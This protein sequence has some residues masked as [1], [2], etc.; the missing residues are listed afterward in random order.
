[1]R[2]IP[3]IGL[4]IILLFTCHV[5]HAQV[6]GIIQDQNGEPLLGASVLIKNTSRGVTT[7]KSGYFYLVSTP[8]TF[9]LVVSYVGS[10]TKFVE[11]K[12]NARIAITLQ[13]EIIEMAEVVIKSG[14]NPAI[15][16][17]RKTIE[18][19]RELNKLKDHYKT[20]AYTKGIVLSKNG[21]DRL[22]TMGIVDS[23]EIR[24]SAGN[25]ILYLAESL[26]ELTKI[27][28]DSKENILSS[29]RS[30]DTRGIALNFL[31]FFNIEFNENYV[32]FQKKVVNPIGSLAFQYYNY[33][34]EGSYY[35]DQQK[36]YKINVI[37][38]RKEEAVFF[39]SIYIAD[40]Y[41]VLKQ[42]DLF[43]RGGN[44]GIDLM[45]SLLVKQSFIQIDKF[46]K[47]MPLAQ[48]MEFKAGFF[49][50]K[51]EGSFL[52]MYNEY[53]M[54]DENEV[55]EDKKTVIEFDKLAGKK[56]NEYWDSLRPIKL[57]EGEMFD[58]KKRDSIAIVQ[59]GRPYLDSMDRV[60]NEFKF[61]NLFT[62][63]TYRNTFRNYSFTGSLIGDLRF[64]AVQGFSVR[65]QVNFSKY[66]KASEN[67]FDV[68]VQPIY[69]FAEEKFRYYFESSWRHRGVK[70]YRI[71]F[72]TGHTADN[73]NTLEPITPLANG[74]SS[75]MFKNNYIKF[76]D[77]RFAGLS[78]LF[79]LSPGLSIEGAVGA[80][81]RSS[82]LN[83]TNYSVRKR[84][85][86]YSFNYPEA[87]GLNTFDDKSDAYTTQVTLKYQPGNKIL[88]FP[89]EAMV[90]GSRF[91]TFELVANNAWALKEGNAKYNRVS[92][93]IKNIRI[94]LGILGE[95]K[96]NTTAGLFYGHLPDYKVD[97]A[98]FPGNI[99]FVKNT[100]TY[101]DAFKN[102]SYYNYSTNTKYVT[103]FAEWN[104][105]GF[106]F[107]KIPLL[108]KTGFEEVFSIN[109]L[110]TP[111]SKNRIEISAGIDRIG[112][113]PFRLFR[114]D[115]FWIFEQGKFVTSNFVIGANINAILGALGGA[116][117]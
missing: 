87:W 112:Y 48:T 75:L 55:I 9:T 44:V 33:E 69:G 57:T 74:Y 62:S 11:T 1:M 111:E 47:W 108:N 94:P 50:I 110:M 46:E 102:L 83:N 96:G 49:G 61:I 37:P 80:S 52:G 88:Q 114:F 36:Y 98:H 85:R 66:W 30:G 78:A 67:R 5:S 13:E 84:E 65:P 23:T 16:I 82:L 35:E 40:N 72:R 27:G 26:T 68:K 53:E 41:F 81:R 51:F 70:A 25:I 116:A 117:N 71:R 73:Y 15:P 91:P 6:S 42:V 12:R 103:W 22:K 7:N 29:R 115:Y 32:N 45:D 56:S 24:D 39:G 77:N 92:F 99:I 100:N 54:L 4:F 3:S 107:K 20:K 43:T 10:K 113:G 28:S 93:N 95:V 79:T 105:K 59:E 106:L 34:L 8:D 109:G 104:L 60:S 89:D 38:K 2:F 58:Y 19:R 86:D 18:K 64:D 76:F 97:Y 63:Y 90:I 17:I 14:E 101:L 31:Q 21:Y